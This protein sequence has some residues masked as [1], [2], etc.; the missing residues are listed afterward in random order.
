MQNK[1]L[2]K[3]LRRKLGNLMFFAHMYFLGKEEKTS[4]NKYREMFSFQFVAHMPKIR[5]I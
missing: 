2:Q 5:Q 1:K 4:D 3:E